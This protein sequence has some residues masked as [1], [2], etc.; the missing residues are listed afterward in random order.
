M[1][2][3]A[4]DDHLERDQVFA[5]LRD[6]K[7][8]IFLARLNIELVHGLDGGQILVNDGIDAASA[9]FHV[10]ADAAAQAHV[11]IG[12]NKDA[13][14]HLITQRLL[15]EDHNAFHHDD[16]AR[17]DVQNP[18]GA[19]V[20]GIVIRR[21]VDGL[22]VFEHAQML[23][24]HIGVER[25]RAVVIEVGSL[26]IAHL[27]VPLVIIVVAEDADIVAEAVHQSLDERGFSAA[28]SAGNTDDDH[29]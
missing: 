19:V 15:D 27:V 7:I 12:V 4:V 17:L 20:D 25:V 10:A 16:L 2:L 28:G 9:F 6:D 29:I 24:H 8:R 11:S 22:T 5:A 13:D 3:D 26:L 1:P 18:V 23:D 21:A 14:V